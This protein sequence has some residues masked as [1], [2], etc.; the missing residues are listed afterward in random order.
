MIS[1]KTIRRVDSPATLRREHEVAVAE[2]ERLP[3]QDPR[4]DCPRR[5]ADDQHEHHRP[6]VL[7]EGR[8]HDQQRQGGDDEEDVR[9]EVDDVVDPAAAVGGEEPEEHGDRR[10]DD[11]RE[12]PDGEGLTCSPDDLGEDVVALI[13][14]AEEELPARG[15]AGEAD[16]V[17]RRVRR[18]PGGGKGTADDRTEE[19]EAESRLPVSEQEARPQRHAEAAARAAEPEGGDLRLGARGRDELEIGEVA[20][21][22]RTRG[23]RTTY[24]R[25][26]IR[27]AISTQQ[28]RTSSS[29]WVSG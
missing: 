14:R 19:H 12:R 15:L 27:F 11:R 4:L 17:A 13:G 7:H 24:S 18:E 28:A 21:A 10:R 23:S 29:A 16:D 25:S 9:D 22:V 3:A 20:H 8:D 26:M 1:L 6:P 2:R 5:K